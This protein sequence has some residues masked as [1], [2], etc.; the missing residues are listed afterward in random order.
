MNIPAF[1]SRLTDVPSSDPDDAR[2]RKLLNILLIGTGA[3]SIITLLMILIASIF[4]AFANP[5]NFWIGL[6][7]TFGVLLG[8]V[9]FLVIN[10][11]QKIPGW[12]SAG[13]FLLFLLVA[14]GFTDSPVELATGRSLFIFVVPVIMASIL[15][16]PSSSFIFA[17]LSAIEIGILSRVSATALNW[18]AIVGFFLVAFI[19]WLSARSLEQALKDLRDI[20]SNLDRLVEQKTRELANAL[21]RE[22]ILAGR[23]QAILNSIADGVIVFDSNNVAI[24][25]NPALSQLTETPLPNLMGIRF[26]DLVDN[27]RLSATYRGTMM[28]LLENPEKAMPGF[29]VE[30]GRRTLSTSMAKVQDTAGENIGTVAVFRDVSR[31]AELEKMKDTFIAIVS[32]ELRTPLSA[33]LGFAEMMKESVYGPLNEKQMSIADRIL[34]NVQRLLNMVGDL[35]DEAQIRAGKLSIKP[36]VFKTVSLLE[37]LHHTMDKLAND[38]G[39]SLTGELDSKMPEKLRGDPHRLQQVLINLVNNAIKFTERGGIHVHIFASEPNCWNMRVTDT[40]VGIPE[41]EIE[42]IFETFRQVDNVT[43]RRQGGFGL[44]LS[45]VKQLVELMGGEVHVKSEEGRGSVFTATLPL[46]TGW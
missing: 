21:S 25:A 1:L 5:L 20:N 39:L 6:A 18:F 41:S 38:K 35:L 36:Q 30:W 37:N 13:L 26:S 46:E 10:R 23:N 45:I 27:A 34:I 19:S 11:N 40:G 8:T 17:V 32:H 9:F 43:T 12:M 3:L 4:S 28:A 24:L 14:F 42:H 7:S 33:I 44:G 22:L 16:R 2:R 15:L 31:E 29:R